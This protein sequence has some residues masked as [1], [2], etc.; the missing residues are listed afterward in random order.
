MDL[1]APDEE[2]E[3]AFERKDNSYS[4]FGERKTMAVRALTTHGGQTERRGLSPQGRPTPPRA[5]GR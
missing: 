1:Q 3:K 2:K 4:G 5:L